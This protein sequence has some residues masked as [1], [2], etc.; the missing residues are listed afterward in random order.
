MRQGTEDRGQRSEVRGQRSEV[1]GQIGPMG[2][3]GPIQISD[4]SY[5]SRIRNPRRP[6]RPATAQTKAAI[7]AE[8]PMTTQTSVDCL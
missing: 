7:A 8:P 5:Q 4:R 1:R 6:N 2:R 3:I